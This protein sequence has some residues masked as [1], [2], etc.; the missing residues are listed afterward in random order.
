MAEFKLGRIR[1]VWKADWAGATTYYKDDVI[2]YGGKT[3]ISTIGHTSDADFY[4]DLNVSPS[5]WNQMTDGQDW[6]GSWGVSTY[7][8]TNDL[9]KYGGQIY[10]CTTP[11]TSAATLALG[12]E[13]SIGNWT[14]YAEGTE[15]K[16]DWAVNTRYKI[17]DLVR[18][19]ATTY[20]CNTGHTSAS[21]AASGLEANQ[22]N[23]DIF[24]QGLLYKGAWATGTR[25]KLN[26]IVKQGAGTYIC[27]TQHTSHVSTFATDAANWNQFIEGFEY[28]STWNGS[29]VYQPG[30]VVKYGGNQYV[31][32]LYH[33]GSTNPSTDSTNWDL[34]SEGFDFKNTW[35]NATD[36]K[37][38][39]IVSV[40]GNSYV[41][42]Q[43]SLSTDFTVTNTSNSTNKFTVAST[44]GIVVGQSIYFSG[45]S[46]G[47]VNEG[48]TYYIK[49]VDDATTFTISI[50]HGGAVFVP[51]L[52]T[53]TMTAR[54]A[55]HPIEPNYWSKLAS[56]FYWAGTWADDYEYETGD[57]VKFGDNSYV[58]INKHRSEG[59]G[60]S[61]IGPQ[62]GGA[63]N[64]RPDLDV[65]G[66][67]WNQMITGSETSLLTTAG[68]IVYYGGA[69][70]ARLPIGIEGQVL[71]AG[72]DYPEWRSMGSN[73]FV[74]FVAE[75]GTNAPYPVHGAT[76]DKPWAS[77]RYACEAVLNGP[78]NPKSRRLLEMN[79]AF[80]QR[81]VTEWIT[82]KIANAGGSGIW[83]AFA[84][85]DDRCERDVGL[86]L[87]ALV[88]DMCHG[89]NKRSRGA[90]NA[91]VGAL[92]EAPYNSGPYSN[93]ATEKENSAEAYAYMLT[94]VNSVLAQTDPTVN[95]QTTNGDNST[96]IV[97]QFKEATNIA[98]AGTGVVLTANLKIITDA[99][100]AGNATNIPA[101][102]SPQN[103]IKIKTGQFREIG[104]IIVPE[105]TVVLGDEVRSTNV[106]PSGPITDK[107]DAFYTMSALSRLE[108]VLGDVIKGSSVT[109]TSGNAYSQDIAV[110]F[111]DTVEETHVEKLVRTMKKNID[112]RVGEFELR[113]STDPTGYNASYLVGYGSARQRLRENKQFFKEEL[114]AFITANYPTVKYSKRKCRQDTGY[115]VDSLCYDLTYGGLSQSRIA[116]LAYY[117]GNSSVYAGDFGNDSGEKAATIAAYNK[118]KS[119]MQD[120]ATDTTVTALQSVHPQY[121]GT[122]GSAAASTH[123]SNGIDIIT[124]VIDNINNQPKVT[125]TAVASNVLT[126]VGHG[127]QVGDTFVPR[128]NYG[129]TNRLFKGDR[130]WVKTAPDADT[131]TLSSTFGGSAKTA[132][133]GSSLTFIGDTADF[134]TLANGV[135]STSALIT[136]AETLDAAQEAVVTGVINHLNPTNYHTLF[137][138]DTVPS[139]VRI[140]TYVGTSAYAHTYVSGGNVTKADGTVLN[141]TAVTYNNTSGVMDITVNTAHGLDVN[142]T[143]TLAN[144]VFSCNSPSGAD[145]VYP[146]ATKTDGVTKK[147]LYNQIKCLRDVRLITEAVMFD[148]A[149]N[150]NEQTLRAGLS[151]LR[152]TAKDVYDLDQKATTR[153]AFEY[154]RTQAIANVGGDATAIARINTLMQDLDD[155]VYSGS[156]EGSPCVTEARNAHHAILQI[157]R[158]R[159]FIVAESTAYIVATYTDTVT[160]TISSDDSITISDTSWLR[161]GTAVK[162][163]GTLLSEPSV[164]GGDGFALSTTYYVNKI[165][166]STKFT[167]AKNKNNTTAMAVLD[168]TGSMTV[169]LDYSSTQCERDV[170]RI[171]DAIKYDLQYH[172]NYKSLQA[173][174]YYGNAVHGTRD[175]EDFYYVR[176][177]TGVRNQTLANMAGELLG[178]NAQGTS[179]VSGGAYVSLDPG[180]GPD[181]FSTWII[182]R[183]PYIQN[184]ATF[185]SGAVGQKIDG[186]LHNGGNDSIVSN[187]FTQVISDGIGAWITNNGRAELVSVFT[188]Y[189][190][191]GYLAEN[192]GRIRGTNG[193]NS[194]G[195]FGSVAEGFDS[196]EIPNT[197][198]VDNKFQFEATVGTVQTD[199]AV[200]VYAFEFDNAGNEY[201]NA[202]WLMSGAG[203]GATAVADEFRTGGVHQI[204][205]QD[206]VDDSSKA[207]EADGNFGGFGYITN[208]NTAQAGSSTSITLAATDAEISSAYIGMRV[209]IT[210]GAGVGQFGIVTAYNSGTKVAA[211]KR[212]STSVAGWDHI[213]AGT[214]IVTP[215]ASTTYTVEPTISFTAPTDSSQ[216]TGALPTSG[217]WVDTIHGKRTGVYLPSATY[218]NSG[219]SGASFQVIKNGGKYVTTIVSGGTTYTRLNTFTIAG[220][221]VGGASTAN[222]I[223]ITVTAISASGTI[224]DIETVGNAQEGVWVAVKSSANAGAYSTNGNTWVAN[225]MPNANWTSLAHGLIDDGSTVALQSR[226]VAV[227]T[228]SAIAAYSDDGVTWVQSALPSSQAWS[229]VTYGEGKF[230]AVAAGTATVAISLDGVAW[231]LT[232]TLNNTGHT[233]ITYGAGR[234]VATK[235][236]STV[237]EYSNDGVTWVAATLPASR[238]WTDVAF[239]NGHFVAVASDNNTGAMSIDGATWVAMPMGSP[240]STAVSGLQKVNYG[241]GLFVATAYLDGLDGFNEVATSQDGFNWTW[242]S[243]EGVSGDQIGEGY[244]AVA[245]GVS[246]RKGYWVT[247]PVVAGTIAS[248]SRLGVR[249]RARSYVAQN[250][251]YSVKIIEP[252][253]GYDSVPTMTIVDPSEIYAAPFIVRIGNG[254]LANPT[255]SS[256]GTGY[257]SSSAD[258]T[259]GDG[260]ADF[261]QS[262]SYIAVR[263][264]S[265]LPVTGSN[266]VFGHLPNETFKLVNIITQLGTNPGAFTCFLQVS[267]QMKLINVPAHG[268]SVT[269]RIKY[270]QVRLTGHDFLDIGTGNFTETNYPGLPL[271]DPIQANE[272]RQSNGGRVFYTA[273]DQDGN[274]RVGGLF[275]VEQSTGVATLNA[276]AF[277]IAGLQ[278]LSLGEVTLGGGSAS[279]EEFSTDP[280]FTADSDSVVPTQRAIKAYISSQIGGGGASLNVNSV[281]AGSIYI[282]GTQITTTTQAAILVN[283]NMNFKGGVRGL[284]IAWHY[285]LN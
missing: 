53:G 189:S 193:N 284:P 25:Y 212:E 31:A 92:Y 240:D 215:D 65:T 20:V 183:S 109:K 80:I 3:Y 272:T 217:T 40:N 266:V 261:F 135:N 60:D 59:D 94:L 236:A 281:T 241:E 153:T 213:V 260:Y 197:A 77:V 166:S 32:K 129:A 90:A 180:Y 222:D 100:A 86:V 230:I 133:N 169:A 157:E 113:N 10:I 171:L 30:D 234:F 176:N 78:R 131:F 63:T 275:A 147:V 89:G 34:F 99:I 149:T 225:V 125:V 158:N 165:I 138:V 280:F 196:T 256:R 200:Q 223:T 276:D 84:Y 39:E 148:F 56:G 235:P 119:L 120:V 277:N 41:A 54:V 47:N 237:A 252:G 130:Y 12:L 221:A 207:A 231:D 18:Y 245:Y 55:A 82:Y 209:N 61:T 27:V 24:N 270:S 255:F 210:G 121:R 67:Y 74:Y 246:E 262:G 127:L 110:P 172:G 126:A 87:D 101:R 28:E 35:S 123:I 264:L 140:T 271:Q 219:G 15:W 195:D 2:R 83:N 58:C 265:N 37:I 192:G 185:G 282:A 254:V 251:I 248:R 44:T 205:L 202:T 239:G 190:H 168:A 43:D 95:Y 263:Q 250:K 91:F 159:N 243:L 229:D 26:D 104:P 1:F 21:T 97:T 64:S 16:S 66:T 220:T 259:G 161:P 181:D 48:A 258:L 162:V 22:S 36:Y 244:K 269:T 9:V 45:A 164:V 177:G 142:D 242:R 50:A 184:V 19:G 274:F 52:G 17:N 178:T 227:A 132:D 13:D 214:T 206:N 154:V 188:Y 49:S 124:A 186:A 8:K 139:T 46:Y 156:N 69:G 249:A 73:D 283:A 71:Q 233:R 218:N 232:G 11:H 79:R 88:Y 267:P 5:R 117:E 96:A 204:F 150:S 93:L 141:I 75:H 224:L 107:T 134:P 42:L 23:W 238:A 7:Y 62:G 152:A 155:I 76:I 268:T 70:V 201:T 167:V 111:A 81:E 228:G 122:A 108:G 182:E 146:S 199:G 194:Y 6:K 163:S 116:A 226:F 175:G 253:A 105:N 216:A 137:E 102:Y 173:A 33:S 68:D 198:I 98:E 143:Y 136:A 187:D 174:R 191:I 118:L 57:C 145:V 106:G 103:S 114:I 278:E 151:Y 115:I 203:T 279:I 51:T 257:V 273:T 29:T 128:T 247:I 85:E 160:A 179:R 38:G 112:F 170:N 285:F 208:S 144:I 14:A 72:A 4:T 211:V